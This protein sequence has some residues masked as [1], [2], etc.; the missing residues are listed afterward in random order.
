MNG[1]VQNKF[2]N[3]IR[4]IFYIFRSDQITFSEIFG[5][6]K[7][8]VKNEDRQKRTMSMQTSS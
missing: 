8:M 3:N 6:I 4:H 2:Q 7:M 1:T 5:K